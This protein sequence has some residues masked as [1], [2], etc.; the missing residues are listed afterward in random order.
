MSQGER[1]DKPLPDPNTPI[2]TI[3]RTIGGAVERATAKR[4][5]GDDLLHSD[6]RLLEV[7]FNDRRLYNKGRFNGH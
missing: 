7:I 1:T 5:Y 6:L 3:G 2:P 4:Q